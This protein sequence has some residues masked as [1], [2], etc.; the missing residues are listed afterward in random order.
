MLVDA[1]NNAVMRY[2]KLADDLAGQTV[3]MPTGG[4]MPDF[5]QRMAELKDAREAIQKTRARLEAHRDECGFTWPF[6]ENERV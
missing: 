3:E 4:C 1:L 5:L 6:A 2:A